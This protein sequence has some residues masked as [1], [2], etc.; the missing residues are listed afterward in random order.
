MHHP[1]GNAT[2]FAAVWPE[3]HSSKQPLLT[4]ETFNTPSQKY[5]LDINQK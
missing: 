3:R 5:I 2:V 4:D 1:L